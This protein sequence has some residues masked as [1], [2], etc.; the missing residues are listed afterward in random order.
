M[1]DRPP[2]GQGLSRDELEKRDDCP[3]AAVEE[4]GLGRV[5]RD[6]AT[7][8]SPF[9]VAYHHIEIPHVVPPP[10]WVVTCEPPLQFGRQAP[11]AVVWPPPENRGPSGVG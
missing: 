3:G 2:R 6:A 7:E 1:A 4:Q 8:A 10:F 9:E 5:A 11:A